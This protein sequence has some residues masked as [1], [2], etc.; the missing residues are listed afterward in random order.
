MSF[1]T[2]LKLLETLHLK[3]QDKN[4]HSISLRVGVKNLYS[5][6]LRFEYVRR[7]NQQCLVVMLHAAARHVRH[8]ETNVS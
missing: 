3:L 2:H 1:S 6:S 4:L 5:I 8:L 7:Q